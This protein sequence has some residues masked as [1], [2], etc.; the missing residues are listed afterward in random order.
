MSKLS[1]IIAFPDCNPNIKEFN[2]QFS[3]F[4]NFTK[5]ILEGLVFKIDSF[6]KGERN[7]ENRK[8]SLTKI[9]IV[10]PNKQ[11]SIIKNV[12][13]RSSIFNPQENKIKQH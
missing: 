6:V 3:Q 8:N 2:N 5:Q 1:E 10:T 9:G 12:S 7:E 11:S 4:P 13:N